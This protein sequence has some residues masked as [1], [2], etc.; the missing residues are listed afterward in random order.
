MYL[1]NYSNVSLIVFYILPSARLTLSTVLLF[2]PLV[3][4]GYL[5]YNQDVL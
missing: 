3:W 4:S 5:E 2:I 1:L